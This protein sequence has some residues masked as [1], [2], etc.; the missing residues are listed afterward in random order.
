MKYIL[1]A[2][3][4]CFSF[5]HINAQAP[6]G[7]P[8]Q[9]I[10]RNGNGNLL[11]N[12]SVQVRFTIHDSTMNG[13]I[14]YQETHTTNTSAAA[15]IILTIGQGTPV[16]GNFS[17][18]NWGNGAKFM[19]VELDATGG[20]NY[21]DLGTQ[22]MMS[23]PFALYAG[24]GLKNGTA[25]GEM[26][27]WNGTAW[28]NVAPGIEGQ[29]LTFHNGTPTWQDKLTI[30]MNYQG[31]IIAYI[32]HQ[33]DPGYDPNTL[34]GL[35]AAP[36]DQSAAAPWGCQEYN[37]PGVN[38]I[39]LSGADGTAIGTGNQNTIDIM[40]GC[41]E[42]G[43]AA[44]ICGDLVLNG[45]SDWYLPSKDELVLLYQNRIAI[46]AFVYEYGTPYLSSTEGAASQYP[47]L[48]TYLAWAI[49]FG[50]FPAVNNGSNNIGT[51][52]GNGNAFFFGKSFNCHVRAIRSF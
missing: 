32:L 17:T 18:I 43:I 51:I 52:N 29:F 10:I 37:Y 1:L 23:V 49:N 28:V 7:I 36:F 45:Y 19:Q 39:G 12:Q 35:I 46:G 50:S 14:V 26:M 34:H 5:I 30:G 8:Y 22:Q 33:G 3:V 31:G 16:T 47:Y 40:N 6:Q 9:S 25:S 38:Q 48:I 13:N 4:C 15:M 2:L 20:N 11:I 42:A 44:R 41:S 27:Y 21:V 24:N